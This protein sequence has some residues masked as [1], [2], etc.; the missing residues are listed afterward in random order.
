ML[1]TDSMMPFTSL[2]V[3]LVACF[4][5]RVWIKSDFERG[6]LAIGFPWVGVRGACSTRHLDAGRSIGEVQTVA[7]FVRAIPRNLQPGRRDRRC[8][9]QWPTWSLV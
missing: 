8:L 2:R 9:R 6:P 1:A 7:D 3:R 5:T 4:S